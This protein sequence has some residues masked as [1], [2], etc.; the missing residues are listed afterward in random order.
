MSRC[1]GLSSFRIWSVLFCFHGKE[2]IIIKKSSVQLKKK[3]TQTTSQGDCSTRRWISVSHET[4]QPRT[5][6]NAQEGRKQT[7]QQRA[8]STSALNCSLRYPN[9]TRSTKTPLP[10]GT[11]GGVGGGGGGGQ[12]GAHLFTTHRAQPGK[13]EPGRRNSVC[14]EVETSSHPFP[15]TVGGPVSALSRQGLVQE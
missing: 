2:I 13:E 7:L 10:G 8:A 3:P 15:L 14:R 11:G 4:A 6:D 9:E 12:Q 1:F 5:H